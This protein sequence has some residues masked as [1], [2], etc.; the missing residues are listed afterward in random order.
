[1]GSPVQPAFLEAVILHH[2]DMI[3][4]Q[5]ETFERAKKDAQPGVSRPFTGS[6]KGNILFNR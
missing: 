6:M 1:M 3:D 2:L 4:S 5:G